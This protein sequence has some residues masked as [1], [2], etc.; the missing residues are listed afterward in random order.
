MEVAEAVSADGDGGALLSAGTNV[1][2]LVESGFLSGRHGYP[3]PPR[4]GVGWFCLFSMVYEGIIPRCAADSERVKW[5]LV[6][7]ILYGRIRFLSGN[8]KRPRKRRFLRFFS[9]FLF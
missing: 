4:V 6:F 9:L 3:P 7:S 1:L 5:I 8:E 2:A